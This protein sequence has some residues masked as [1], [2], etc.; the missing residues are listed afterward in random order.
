MGKGDTPR[1]TDKEKYD[2]NFERIFGEHRLKTW[3]DA[4]RVGEGSG[5]DGGSGNKLSEEPVGR[6]D[7][8]TTESVESPTFNHERLK[9]ISAADFYA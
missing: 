3:E 4:P 7:P 5:A 1:P 8:E 9:D 2:A 6:T